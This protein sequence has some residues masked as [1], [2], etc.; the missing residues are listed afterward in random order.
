MNGSFQPVQ[1]GNGNKTGPAS[2]KQEHL[3][4]LTLDAKNKITGYYTVS[5]G[6]ADSATGHL[7]D[8]FRNLGHEEF[9][10]PTRWS[11]YNSFTETAKKYSPARADQ[12]YQRLAKMF[13]LV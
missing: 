11:L 3:V 6:T 5:I 4:A 1:N 10:E 8:V 7:R 2:E 13:G 12:C 9:R